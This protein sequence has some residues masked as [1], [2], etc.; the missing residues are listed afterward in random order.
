MRIRRTTTFRLTAMLGLAFLVA[1]V[2]LLG[3]IYA[4]TERELLGRT[5]ALLA[6]QRRVFADIP[7]ARLP[8]AVEAAIRSSA[9][10][11][12]HFALLDAQG[13][14]IVGDFVPPAHL[15][16]GVAVELAPRHSDPVALRL[17]P[18]PT[19][20]DGVLVI[21]RDISQI[22][23][24]RRRVFEILLTSGLF[25]TAMLAL[26]AMAL[27]AAPLRRVRALTALATRIGAGEL[28]L[29]MPV[30]RRGDELDVI[31]VTLNAMIEEIARLLQQVKGATDAIAHDLRAPLANLRGQLER[32]RDAAAPGGA[33]P[34]AL[35]ELFDNALGDLDIVLLRFGALLRIAE[36][37]ATNRQA[38]F[39]ELDPMALAASVCELFGPLAEDRGINLLQSGN[40]GR[41]IQGDEKLLFE[42]VSNLVEN[43][44]K[45]IPVGGTVTVGVTDMDGAPVLVVRDDGPGI[46]IA[47]R[48]SVLRRY[49]RGSAAQHSAGSGLGLSLVAEIVH[50][51]GFALQLEDARPGLEVRIICAPDITM[52]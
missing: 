49:Y 18:V 19:P 35:S 8:R 48:A 51:H 6:Y 22:A 36:L 33:S 25:A 15:R 50:L 30:S 29:R 4:L 27:S 20:D 38:G 47:E 17:L 28:T 44:I 12:N 46:P 26:A 10:H 7:A 1:M 52:K 3:L 5:D 39:T 24:L 31:A 14:E 21:A 9:D 13:H 43:A 45:F 2:G 37:E 11:L 40:W 42:V 32:L 41:L 34:V 16:P 23:D